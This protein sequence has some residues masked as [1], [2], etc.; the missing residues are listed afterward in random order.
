[1]IKHAKNLHQWN[2]TPREAIALQNRLKDKII[3]KDSFKNIKTIAGADIAISKSGMGCAG[4]IVFSFPEIE[5]IKRASHIGKVKFPYIPGLLSFREAP[6]LI[7]AFERLKMSPDIVMFDGQGI[8]HPRR[9]GLASH[10]GL[11]L[12]TPTIGC[13]KSR[14]IG[15]YEEP[16]RNAGSFMHLHDKEEIIGAVVRTRTGARPIFVSPG[17]KISLSTAIDITLKCTDGLR[18]PKPTRLADRFVRF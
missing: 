5:E 3:L 6:L 2:L 9:M 13:A 14:L 10:M 1:M 11:L 18:I 15:E 4:V 12:D 7:K 16:P 8:A 17:H